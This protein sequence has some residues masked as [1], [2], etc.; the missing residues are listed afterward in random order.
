MSS[1]Y[2]PKDYPA[3]PSFSANSTDSNVKKG[4]LPPVSLVATRT[5][6]A[7]KASLGT[8]EI[9]RAG[10][11]EFKAVEARKSDFKPEL[12]T[13]DSKRAEAAKQ[14]VAKKLAANRKSKSGFNNQKPSTFKAN[15]SSATKNKDGVSVLLAPPK[16]P[17]KLTEANNTFKLGMNQVQG[18]VALA[19]SSASRFLA[20]I[21][22]SSLLQAYLSRDADITHLFSVLV[23]GIPVGDFISV[24]GFESSIETFSYKEL[25]KNDG[26]HTLIGNLKSGD[27]TL[28]WG[29]M[30]RGFLWDWMQK[31]QVGKSFKQTVVI[32]QMTRQ[33]IPIRII[34]IVDAWPVGWKGANLNAGASDQAV[35][36]VRLSYGSLKV[37]AIPLPF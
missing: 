35:E 10:S 21:P 33:K 17:S 37:T 36:E 1:P 8:A 3:P 23:G 19:T 25:G 18:A 20:S 9:K 7:P 32:L 12:G 27:I 24:E 2:R 14:D 29:L 28:K 4:F 11:P 16:M 26:A 30:N 22:G 34:T 15:A 5:G 13:A 31:V 6:A